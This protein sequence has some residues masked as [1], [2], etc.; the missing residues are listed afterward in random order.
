LFGTLAAGLASHNDELA[1]RLVTLGGKAYGTVRDAARV[2]RLPDLPHDVS[3]DLDHVE[4][5]ADRTEQY[6]GGV[7]EARGA[8]AGSGTSTRLTG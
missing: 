8:A 7:R 3:R 6:L 4:L 2:S 1:E 5:L